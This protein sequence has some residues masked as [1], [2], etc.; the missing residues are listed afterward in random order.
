[1]NCAECKE[2]LV[3][4]VEGFLDES[5]KQTVAGHLTS[6][7]SCRAELDVV[8]GLRERLVANGKVLAQTALENDVMNQIVREQ[9]VRLK[10]P[11]RISQAIGIRRIL[12]KNPIVKLA[13][14]AV[15]VIGVFA[16]INFLGG[17]G[18]SVTLAAVLERVEQVQAFM[19]KMK[20]NTTGNIQPGMPPGEQQME[21]TITISTEYGMKMDMDMNMVV[22]GAS[23]K[24]KQLMYVLPN[25]KKVYMITPEQKQYITI[26]FDESVLARMK[27]Q[28]NDPREFLRQVVNSKYTDI[29][30]SVIDGV[31]VEGFETTDPACLGGMMEDVKVTLW[32]DRKTELP[33]REEMHYK[34]NDQMQMEVELYDFQW[35]AQVNADEFKPVIPQDYTTLLPGGYKMPSAS[36]EGAIEGLRFCE[37]IMGRYPKKIDMMNLMNEIV[38]IKDS[39]SPTG[40]ALKLKEEMDKLPEEE[41]AKK[42]MEIMRPVQSLG[43]FYMML[44]QDKKE[45]AYYGESVTPADADRV[46]M[47]WKV[48]DSEYRVIY[49]DLRVETITAEKLAE[50]EAALPK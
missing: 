31:E 22:N 20:M 36:E 10:T 1:M 2:L 8:R 17:T 4:Y 30:K 40:A 5:Q 25:E 15:I 6:C 39:N 38:A 44:A 48:S 32:V 11:N 13:A 9:N 26:E 28:S 23:Q 34:M 33:V 18:S 14:A 41:K 12:M 50:L 3:G 21:G 7:R 19:Y 47:R 29:G 37:Q 45:P 42:I 16:V 35:Y 46:L 27:K 49:G 24:M 43:M